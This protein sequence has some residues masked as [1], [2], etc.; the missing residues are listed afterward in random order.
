M[1]DVCPVCNAPINWAIDNPVTHDGCGHYVH[2]GTCCTENEAY[3][4][5]CRACAAA[6][7]PPSVAIGVPQQEEVLDVEP[8]RVEQGGLFSG[9]FGWANRVSANMRN[10]H[11]TPHSSQDIHWLVSLG[12]AQAP[13]RLL[14]QKG[15]NLNVCVRAGISLDNFLQGGYTIGDL[16]QFP[17][18]SPQLS[19]DGIVP[20]GVKALQALRTTATHLKMYTQQLPIEEVRRHTGL[21]NKHLV[22]RFW[23]GF[24]PDHGLQSAISRDSVDRAWTID[25][26]RYLGFDSM[27]KLI[28]ELG[29]KR[30]S[31]WYKL[32]PTP[33]D[34][35]NLGAKEEHM[36]RLIND[37]PPPQPAATPAV[38]I[39]APPSHHN[40]NAAVVVAGP[41]VRHY[42][43][44]NPVASGWTPVGERA[45][46]QKYELRVG[47][48]GRMEK[49]PIINPVETVTE[50]V[51][52]I[53][54][55]VLRLDYGK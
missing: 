30:V 5:K 26:L 38:V 6:T 22:E 12:P 50:K 2:A 25:Q 10:R 17:R 9:V 23:M 52:V 36:S 7:P 44:V 11:E 34:I 13:I 49:V 45:G 28:N 33:N 43:P 4:D 40:P 42:Q 21:T 32:G 51:G 15:F 54:N 24:H 1:S 20:L 19:P 53:S 37:I 14:L 46:A 48:D 27:D 18:M 35:H 16:A 41:T 3:N 55:G 31:H 29:L 39:R 47:R 8:A